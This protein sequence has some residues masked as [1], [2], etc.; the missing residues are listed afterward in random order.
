MVI[1]AFPPVDQANSDG[2][3]AVGGDLEIESLLLA[4]RSGIF[5]WPI[6]NHTLAWFCPPKRALLFID[7]LHVSRTLKK[8]QR[9]NPYSFS[10]DHSFESVITACANA[11]RGGGT[12]ITPS[13]QAAYCKLHLAGYAHSVEVWRE[14]YLVGGLYGVALAGM[15]AG[16]SMFHHESDTSKLAL[17]HLI[18]Q[19]RARGVKWIDCQVMTPLFKSFGARL[20]ARAE[21]LELLCD[22]LSAAKKTPR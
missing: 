22:S 2:L 21:F 11:E 14:N 7:Q 12:W 1:R 13:L 3:L 17:L 20:V 4:Y 5:P 15:F 6:D 8:L 16:E 19:L 18:E 10:I 9:S